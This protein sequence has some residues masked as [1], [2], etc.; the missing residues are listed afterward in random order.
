MPDLAERLLLMAARKSITT[1]FGWTHPDCVDLQE[2][3]RIIRGEPEQKPHDGPVDA[4][5]S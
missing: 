1:P 2:A 5:L 4:V 3:A